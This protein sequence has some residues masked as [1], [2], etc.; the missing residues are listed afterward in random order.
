MVNSAI[1][2]DYF[3]K[4]VMY[5]ILVVILILGKLSMSIFRSSSASTS[6]LKQ[7][8]DSVIQCIHFLIIIAF[9]TA[10]FTGDS[11]ELHWLHT[12]CGYSLA[13][14][15]VSRLIWQFLA[16][17]RPFSP[18]KRWQ[19][20]RNFIPTIK[21]QQKPLG[22]MRHTAQAALPLSI[23]A[24]ISIAPILIILGY[25]TENESFDFKE[26]HELFAN[27]ALAT[28][29]THILAVLLISILTKR[30][31]AKAMFIPQVPYL[32]ATL[33]LIVMGIALFGLAF[34]RL[35]FLN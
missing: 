34:Y 22:L 8:I 30:W 32:R 27:T 3:F 33:M 7:P 28:V 12:L 18:L 10:Y 25:L 1:T 26:W 6:T 35:N 24:F 5:C 23:V 31:L 11:D 19:S 21:K 14:L 4:V 15:L 9:F 2:I 13:V 17:G 29:I 16:L 20:F